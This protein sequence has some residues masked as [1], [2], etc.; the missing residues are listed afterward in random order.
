VRCGSLVAASP[1]QRFV[2]A[3]ENLHR[4][5]ADPHALR[6]EKLDPLMRAL[7]AKEPQ[8]REWINR[9]ADNRQRFAK[10]PIGAIRDADLGIDEEILEQLEFTMDSIAR[11]LRAKSQ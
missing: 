3:A 2:H 5:E 6:T 11:K 4:C 1:I 8:L 10:D 9:S 7:S